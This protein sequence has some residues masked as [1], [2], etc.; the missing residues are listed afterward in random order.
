M[1]FLKKLFGIPTPTDIMRVNLFM[2]YNPLKCTGRAA[3]E[4]V[5]LGS[6]DPNLRP[7][8]V[9]LFYA[10]I[11]YAHDETR[12][13]LFELVDVVSKQNVCD[14]GRTGFLFPEWMLTIGFG[15]PKQRIWPWVLVES[16]LTLNKPAVYS[17]TLQTFPESS[18]WSINLKMALAQ[19][20]VLAPASALIAITTYAESTD[21]QGRY[22]LAALLW[23][24]NEFYGSPDRVSLGSESKALAFAIDAIRN[25]DLVIPEFGD[26][27]AS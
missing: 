24:L 11:L 16:H 10:R 6:E 22:E 23:K 1:G 12:T 4:W 5:F 21:Q 14:K 13:R 3:M 8:L 17:T 7:F 25:I 18:L 20:R 15:A 19:T 27:D 26:R 9:A 2:E